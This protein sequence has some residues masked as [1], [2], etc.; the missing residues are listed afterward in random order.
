[1]PQKEQLLWENVLPAAEVAFSIWVGKPEIR[2]A[3]TAWRHIM[4]VGLAN[5]ASELEYCKVCLRFL[6]LADIY[7]DWCSMVWGE[8]HPD[9][10]ILYASECFEM[11]SFRLGQLIGPDELLEEDITPEE[12]VKFATRS[13]VGTTRREVVQ[14]ILQG[15]GGTMGLL[16]S[17]YNSTKSKNDDNTDAESMSDTFYHWI[18]EGCPPWRV[19]AMG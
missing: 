17:L 4:K 10:N 14:A 2:W 18:K 1:M 7:Y 9:D 12:F 11:R 19:D 6:A 13:L 16:V 8:D 15:Y 3:K 5:Y